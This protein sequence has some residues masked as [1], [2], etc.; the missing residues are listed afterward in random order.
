ME[1]LN[2]YNLQVI[3]FILLNG[4]LA[5]S[6]YITLMTG[7]LSLGHAGFMSIGAYTASILTKQADLPLFA[8]LVLGAL[9]AGLVALLIG[10]PTL[11]LHGLYLAI[12]TLG[13]GEVVRVIMLNL[14]I[15][16]GALGITGLKSVGNVLYDWAKAVGLTAQKAGISV[17]QMKALAT[18]LLLVLLFAL[19]LCMTL[20]LNRS[21]IGRAFEAIKAD[22]TAAKAMGLQIAYYKMLAFVIGSVLAGFCGA[23]FAHITTTVTPDDFNY[24]KVV[25]I[26]SFAVIGGSEIVWGPLFGALLLT[27]LPELLRVLAEYKM[28]MYGAIMVLVMAFRP[29]GLIAADTFQRLF[30]SRRKL[31][32]TQKE[33]C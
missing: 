23:L 29:H 11:K 17:L 12:A 4:I 3:T 27:S 14:E 8:A 30:R 19:I 15:T 7:Q 6:I 1:L 24:H 26:L 33:E 22:E 31:Q 25:E 28:I 13:F 5:I 2:P 18:L 16:N 9:A 21:R 10:A 20:R 32:A